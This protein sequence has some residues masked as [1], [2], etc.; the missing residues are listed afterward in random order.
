MNWRFLNWES[1]GDIDFPSVM[2]S[3]PAEIL[4]QSGRIIA[5]TMQ[6]TARHDELPQ[7]DFEPSDGSSFDFFDAI[8]WRR[9]LVRIS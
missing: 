2:D 8:A 3:G 4:T 6:V 7:I 1:D 9:T 5:G